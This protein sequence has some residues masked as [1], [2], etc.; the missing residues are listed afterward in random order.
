MS[1]ALA[2]AGARMRHFGAGCW[3][4]FS[5]LAVAVPEVDWGTRAHREYRVAGRFAHVH[6]CRGSES[7]LR[8][9][10]LPAG[11]QFRQYLAGP[12][13]SDQVVDLFSRFYLSAVRP[14]CLFRRDLSLGDAGRWSPGGNSTATVEN[15]FD[16]DEHRFDCRRIFV[17][18]FADHPPEF[19]IPVVLALP[20]L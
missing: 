20:A 16:D 13:V 3:F 1:P 11:A 14:M 5:D 2:A 4:V 10:R 9:G 6:F 12:G 7:C 15:T 18:L 17:H 19:G 8:S